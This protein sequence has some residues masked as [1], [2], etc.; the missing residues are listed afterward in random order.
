[1]WDA[2]EIRL[3]SSDMNFLVLLLNSVF[4]TGNIGSTKRSTVHC[5][6]SI[7]RLDASCTILLTCLRRPHERTFKGHD[8]IPYRS[9]KST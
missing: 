2:I 7:T 5:D 9:F 8:I 6:A 1:M 4:Q 3:V